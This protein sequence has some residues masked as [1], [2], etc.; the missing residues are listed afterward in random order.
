MN[1]IKTF[2]NMAK[3]SNLSVSNFE[4]LGIKNVIVATTAVTIMQKMNVLATGFWKRTLCPISS[5][6]LAER[7]LSWA[8]ST[9]LPLLS[10][11]F[12]MFFLFTSFSAAPKEA[13]G[14]WL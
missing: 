1:D 2:K 12:K 13:N 6:D 14:F 10:D 4:H 7:R 9:N 5:S 3:V 11:F 8:Y